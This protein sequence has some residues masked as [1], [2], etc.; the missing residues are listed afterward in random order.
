[1]EFLGEPKF[2]MQHNIA[3]QHQ[4]KYSDTM[5]EKMLFGNGS[6]PKKRDK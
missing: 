5:S 2:E 6:G 4:H 1:M 3:R